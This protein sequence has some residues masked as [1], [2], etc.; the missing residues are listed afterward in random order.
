MNWDRCLRTSAGTKGI[1]PISEVSCVV[2]PAR[3]ADLWVL[4]SILAN[5]FHPNSS[6][7]RWLYPFV[8]LGIYED[9]RHRLRDTTISSVCLVAAVVSQHGDRS[10]EE[11]AGTVELSL[12][13]PSLFLPSGQQYPYISNLAVR[14]ECRR[15]GLARQLLTACE[16]QAVEWGFAHLYLHVL[17]DNSR[18]RPLYDKLGYRLHRV[19]STLASAWFGQPRRLFLHKSLKRS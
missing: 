10:I 9:L 15:R 17:E 8:R 19:E 13:T 4:S 18:A 3:E 14:A 2:R 7:H 5:S 6:W 16:Q 11:L 1:L 12:K